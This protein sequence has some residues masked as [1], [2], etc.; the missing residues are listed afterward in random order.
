MLLD[1]YYSFSLNGSI[2]EKFRDEAGVVMFP[3]PNVFVEGMGIISLDH[4]KNTSRFSESH[5]M[6]NLSET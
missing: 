3:S 2:R 6:N 5:A 1:I 4:S